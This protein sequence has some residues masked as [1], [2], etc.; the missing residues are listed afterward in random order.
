MLNAPPTAIVT[1]MSFTKVLNVLKQQVSEKYS[2]FHMG[3]DTY[4][5]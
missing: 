4:L 2:F 3:E 1:A 5:I